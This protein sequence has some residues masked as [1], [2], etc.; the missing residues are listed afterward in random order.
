MTIKEII[1]ENKNNKSVIPILVI[2]MYENV[3]AAREKDIATL[4]EELKLCHKEID[5]LTNKLNIK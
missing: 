5:Q 3:I 1:I 2:R 4:Q